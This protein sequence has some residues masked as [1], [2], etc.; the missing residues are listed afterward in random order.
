METIG[1]VMKSLRQNVPPDMA[2]KLLRVEMSTSCTIGMVK[3]GRAIENLETWVFRFIDATAK[4]P[5][6]VFEGTLLDLGAYDECIETVIHDTY[7]NEKVRGQYCNV[8]LKT[9]NDTSVFDHMA[10]AI[11]LSHR[12]ALELT[13]LQ[14]EDRVPG[15]RLGLCMLADCTKED[16]QAIADTMTGGMM[17]VNVK[18]CVTNHPPTMTSTQKGILIFLGSLALIM[19]LSTLMDFWLSRQESENSNRGCVLEVMTAF[20]VRRNTILLL[21]KETDEYS[22]AYKLRFLHG[23]RVLSM[24]WIVMGH[25][26]RNVAF[27]MSGL[28]NLLAYSDTLISC[29]GIAG[30]IS[31]DTFFFLSGFLLAYGLLK[32]NRNRCLVA[33]IACVRRFIRTTVPLFFLA[34]C[35]YLLPLIASGPSSPAMYEKFYY[36]MKNYWWALLL[37]VRNFHPELTEGIFGHMWYISTDFQLFVVSVIVLQLFKGKPKTTIGIFIGLSLASCSYNAWQMHGT[38]YMP[39]NLPV[40]ATVQ[41]FMD[42]M[43]NVYVLPTT[44]GVC[45]FSGCIMW[46]LVDMHKSQGPS[47]ALQAAFWCASVALGLTCVF[48]KHSWNRGEQP[49]GEWAKITF[50]FSDKIMWSVFLS[51]ITYACATARGGLLCDFLSWEAF[52]PFS[53]LTYGIYLIHFPFYHVRA[54]ISR[55]R[56]NW[57]IFHNV[58]DS[59][60][61][62]VWASIL[63][64]F[65]FIMCEA[66]TSHLEK[67]IFLGRP[68]ARCTKNSQEINKPRE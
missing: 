58:T 14:K 64:Y 65:M 20:S 51:W 36:D 31:V 39:Y 27:V 25:S 42:T 3:L 13:K 47:K 29:V 8:Y 18:D 52:A 38:S 5:S 34:M 32:Q 19:A 11:Q 45:F 4:V 62:F 56:M 1:A 54:H 44:H 9:G 6:G 41:D 35:F 17:Q 63:G 23:I 49:S 7:G 21:S 48:M 43:N 24:F 67:L 16:I 57:N 59:F 30:I 15:I 37:Q 46:L 10:P 40:P 66:P 28:V 53:K 2:R 22:T 55:E 26:A 50:A 12:R 60:A 68:R 61:V 33:A